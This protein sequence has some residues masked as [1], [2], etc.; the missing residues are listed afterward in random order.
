LNELLGAAYK[1]PNLAIQNIPS[2]IDETPTVKNAIESTTRSL[3]LR[4]RREKFV[5]V[6]K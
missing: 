3:A 5:R 1:L 6:A 4:D 2:S